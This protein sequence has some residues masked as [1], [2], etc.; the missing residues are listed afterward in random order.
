MKKTSKNSENDLKK[1]RK[2]INEKDYTDGPTVKLLEFQI[3]NETITLNDVPDPTKC[4]WR[5]FDAFALTFNAYY[6]KEI[7]ENFL[8]I[9]REYFYEGKHKD[10][11]RYLRG[12]LFF[13][14]RAEHFVGP[15]NQEIY[16][17]RL[18]KIVEDIRLLLQK[19][20]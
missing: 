14:Q 12:I 11:I 8:R 3:P 20:K 18:L 6:D 4:D 16:K 17:K 10:S 15:T 19:N 5:H 9:S 7:H 13:E 1:W 2:F